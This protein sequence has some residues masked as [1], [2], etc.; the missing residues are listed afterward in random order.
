MI[1]VTTMSWW[2]DNNVHWLCQPVT[3]TMYNSTWSAK[4][5]LRKTK[6]WVGL[7]SQP[8]AIH[9]LITGQNEIE[10]TNDLA[11]LAHCGRYRFM[12][13]VVLAMVTNSKKTRNPKFDI[14]EY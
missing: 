1:P 2:S 9:K 5:I 13:P 4:F 10:Q 14:V 11:K 8:E 7:Q 6:S 3:G 12:N